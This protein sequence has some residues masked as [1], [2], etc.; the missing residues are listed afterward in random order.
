MAFKAS[1]FDE[2][3]Q[4]APSKFKPSLFDDAA[5]E[6]EKPAGVDMGPEARRARSGRAPGPRSLTSEEAGTSAGPITTKLSPA[7][8]KTGGAF[9]DNAGK[10]VATIPGVTLADREQD[11]EAAAPL[12]DRYNVLPGGLTMAPPE[13]GG[14]PDS[15]FRSGLDPKR[16]HRLM[17]ELDPGF[18]Q[19]NRDKF[20][21]LDQFEV[22]P[23]AQMVVAGRAGRLAGEAVAP[24]AS[25]AA[26][27]GRLG[28][29]A[30]RVGVPAVEGAV[31]SK[32]L[33]GDLASGAAIGA[34]IPLIGG[35]FRAARGGRN[36]TKDITRGTTKAGKR[37]T[38]DVKFKAGEGGSELTEVLAESPVARR[39]VVV[40]AK[41][42]PAEAAK[43]ITKVID[44]ATGANDAAYAAIQ[45][46]HGGVPLQPIVQRLEGLEGRLNRQGFGVEA[47]AVGRVRADL[48]K[49]Y[50]RDLPDAAATE[51]EQAAIVAAE[52]RLASL[53]ERTAAASAKAEE[54]RSSG[55]TER[56]LFEEA[57]KIDAPQGREPTLLEQARA[58]DA[59]VSRRAAADAGRAEVSAARATERASADAA[60]ESLAAADAE[61]NRLARMTSKAERDFN[62]LTTSKKDP[63]DVRLS[64]QQVRNIRND[65][66]TVA[67]PARTIKPNTRRK[68]LVRIYGVLN[69]EIDDVAAN[70][71]GVNLSEFKARNRRI[72][73]LIPVR[74]ALRARAESE[75]D[76]GFMARMKAK[77]GKAIG[78]AIR[79]ADYAGSELPPVAPEVVGAVTREEM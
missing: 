39:A 33:G 73:T 28:A 44:E 58:L 50:G 24:I 65:M 41:T 8:I 11:L 30:A 16:K 77:P 9:G 35:V 34:A 36:L 71:R 21:Q 23:V 2:P 6:P 4:A 60:R 68:A 18:L 48:L 63:V 40:K 51:A 10:V 3:E 62:R 31:A 19:A 29:A 76:L 53:R 26:A 70:T 69:K 43:D 74:D 32:T 64:A 27:T 57:R 55:T 61:A 67:D 14:P 47:D 56:S 1:L 17:A 59:P 72:S 37:L 5:P 54:L 79:E 12:P 66:G 75:A 38:D 20:Y 52:N 46:Q 22:D 42:A 49:R 25:R 7:Q 78:R 15:A 13:M 45:R